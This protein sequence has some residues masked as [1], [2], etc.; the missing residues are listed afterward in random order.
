MVTLDASVQ[1]SF[2]HPDGE[3]GS[4]MTSNISPIGDLTKKGDAQNAEMLADKDC[5]MVAA[6]TGQKSSAPVTRRVR[7]PCIC[8]LR[9]VGRIGFPACHQKCFDQLLTIIAQSSRCELHLF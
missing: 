5:R 6:L 2:K 4:P 9:D 1:A 8:E 3:V 7:V